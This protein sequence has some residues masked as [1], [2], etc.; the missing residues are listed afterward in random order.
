MA[1]SMEEKWR[2]GGRIAARRGMRFGIDDL[3]LVRRVTYGG[4]RCR[5]NGRT[6][7]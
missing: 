3:R 6:I 1:G 7:S 2:K 5:R 4:R